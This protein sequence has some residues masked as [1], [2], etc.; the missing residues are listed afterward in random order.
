MQLTSAPALALPKG[1]D[2]FV[3]YNDASIKGLGCVL[4]QHDKVIVYASRQLK[5]YEV[6]YMVHGLELVAIVFAL[7]IQKHYFYG[8]QVQIFTDHKSLK[9]LMSYKELNIRQKRWIE[10]IKD[11]D[12]IIDYHLGKINV[13]VY[14]LSRKNKTV[15]GGVLVGD[16]IKLLEL[17]KFKVQL[18]L[19]VRGSLLAKLIVQPIQRERILE[20]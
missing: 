8:T 19:G 17:A 5:P 7:R 13:I 14:A 3:D 2:G 9:Y 11:Y 12:C 6:N 16:K 1:Q 20:A 15:I 18:N 10:L 4:M